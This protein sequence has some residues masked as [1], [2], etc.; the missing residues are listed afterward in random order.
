MQMLVWA[1]FV[2]LVYNATWCSRVQERQGYVSLNKIRQCVHVVRFPFNWPIKRSIHNASHLDIEIY[3]F[4]FLAHYV[5][6][7]C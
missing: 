1:L 4:V 7:R 5:I 6:I 3:T 2:S